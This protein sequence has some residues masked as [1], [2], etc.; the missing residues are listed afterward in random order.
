VN[1]MGYIP[2]LELPV[3]IIIVLVCSAMFNRY[4]IKV[5]V[6]GVTDKKDYI[7]NTN[8]FIVFLWHFISSF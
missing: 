1:A 8:S 5:I 6:F 4:G 2:V 7:I 3:L